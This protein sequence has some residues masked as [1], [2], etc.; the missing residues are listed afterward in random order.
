VKKMTMRPHQK[1]PVVFVSHGA[2][3]LAIEDGEAHRFLKDYGQALGRPGAI[4]VLSA[5]YAA[6]V[7]TATAA[8]FPE[9]IHDF[10]NFAQ[11]LYDMTY[12]APGNPALAS[13]VASLLEDA[14]LPA[15]TSAERGLDHG[16]WIPLALMY[17]EAD[18][19]VVQLSMDPRRGPDYHYRLGTQLAPL[20]EEGVLIIG[21]GGVTHNLGK[22]DWAG[23]HAATPDWA[24]S[25]NEWVADVVTD[26]RIDD[27]LAYRERGPNAAVNHP[28]EEHFFPLLFALG[29][30]A[31]DQPRQRVHHSYTYGALSMDAWQFGQAA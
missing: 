15:T 24:S 19:P 29:A 7:A 22:L 25:F 10:G 6:P 11:S 21:S 26:G 9:T 12:P 20:R 3:T 17:P 13:G 31:G 4:L 14:G 23:T 8:E 18:V 28:S 5:H 16:A 1:Q 27:L 2:P 30:A